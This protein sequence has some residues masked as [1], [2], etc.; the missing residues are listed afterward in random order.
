MDIEYLGYSLWL[1]DVGVSAMSRNFDGTVSIKVDMSKDE[2]KRI[3][4]QLFAK[5]ISNREGE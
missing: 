2:A 4:K 1:H 3:A 5:V